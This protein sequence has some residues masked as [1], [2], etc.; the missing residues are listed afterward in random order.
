MIKNVKDR[1]EYYT[2]GLLAPYPELRHAVMG[3]RGP[4]GEDWGFSYREGV[5]PG[6]I[7]ANID[8]AVGVLG[9]G[10][11]VQVGQVHGDKPLILAPADAYRPRRPE[12]V[13]QGFDAII[14]GFGQSLMIKVADCQGLIVYDPGSRVLALIHSGWR[15]S[16]QN[17]IGQTV[18]NMARTFRLDPANFLACCSPSL[19]PCHA[20]FVNYRTELP[21]AFWAFK[22]DRDRF[23]FT[24][25]SRRQL[26]G[27]GLKDDNVEFSGVCTRCSE[28]FYSYRRGDS[29]RFAII[30]GVVAQ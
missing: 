22:D 24:A 3:R 23:D 5:D 15:G 16:V 2:F 4:D 25:I 28:D 12:D 8:A 21:E 14:S 9:L 13:Y 26:T 17:V 20:E 10:F 11:P 30:A 7:N 6:K 19:G 29:G 18:R 1:I 27:A